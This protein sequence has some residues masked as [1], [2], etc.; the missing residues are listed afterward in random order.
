MTVREFKNKCSKCKDKKESH[1]YP[2]MIDGKWMWLCKKCWNSITV[3][4][5]R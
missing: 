2:F 5:T 3:N 1:L 4:K